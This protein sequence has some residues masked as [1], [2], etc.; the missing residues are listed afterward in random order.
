M[1]K[2]KITKR[3]VSPLIATILIIVVAVI[4]VTVLLTWGRDFVTGVFE[5][6]AGTTDITTLRTS[7]ASSYF[8]RPTLED[9]LLRFS[10]NPPSGLRDKEIIITKYSV[11][12]YSGE[13]DL[14]PE[15]TL[16]AG[17]GGFPGVD[18][19][20]L[21]ITDPRIDLVLYTSNNEIINL[22]NTQYTIPVGPPVLLP[23]VMFGNSRLYIQLDQNTDN[24]TWQT[25]IDYCLDLEAHGY[26]DW[27]LPDTAQA[28]SLWLACPDTDKSNE[29]MN[30]AISATN[31]T[32]ETWVDFSENTYWTSTEISGSNAYEFHMNDGGII[33]FDKAGNGD[34]R[35]RCVRDP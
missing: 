9:S 31:Q 20:S 15:V 3:G 34:W 17:M 29:C 24:M 25:A 8:F 16:K 1:N 23:Y 30:A 12:G 14:D 7:D 21:N 6:D 32:E 2:F 11:V 33:S 28:A 27:Y 35:A 26:D 22:R 18:V 13:F 10:Y 19:S 5:G 4:L